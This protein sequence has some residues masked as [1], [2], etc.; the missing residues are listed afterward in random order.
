MSDLA[1]APPSREG[2]E[3]EQAPDEA[4][5]MDDSPVGQGDVDSRPCRRDSFGHPSGDDSERHVLDELHILSCATEFPARVLSCGVE[6]QP[7]ALL[8][9]RHLE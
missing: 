5:L 9:P 4:G 7:V 6:D 3:R 1:P 2:Q 8:H